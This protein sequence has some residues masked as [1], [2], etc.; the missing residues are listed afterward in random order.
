[1]RNAQPLSSKKTAFWAG[2]IAKTLLKCENA[3]LQRV[4]I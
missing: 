3:A 4:I 1:M 2:E